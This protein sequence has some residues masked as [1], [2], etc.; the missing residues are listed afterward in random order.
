MNVRKL[1]AVVRV[2]GL[3]LHQGLRLVDAS[4]IQY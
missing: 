2:V 4:E 3:P 1:C